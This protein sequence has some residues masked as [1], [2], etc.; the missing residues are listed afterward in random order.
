MPAG[1]DIRKGD[2]SRKNWTVINELNASVRASDPELRRLGSR[3]AQL[4]GEPA[5]A[6]APQAFRLKRVEAD[7]LVCR[8]LIDGEE[9]GPCVSI[10]KAPALRQSAFDGE[11]LEFVIEDGTDD[12]PSQT[13]EYDYFSPTYRT[14]TDGDS[15]TEDQTVIPRWLPDFDVIFAVRVG[16]L[17]LTAPQLDDA[18]EVIDED[19]DEMPIVLQALNL[20]GRAWAAVTA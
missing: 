1:N 18:G 6:S 11:T 10:S 8:L 15:N 12:P 3:M 17:G 2:D 7:Y 19:A 9:I 4:E 13:F 20:D 5:R 16:G 14:V